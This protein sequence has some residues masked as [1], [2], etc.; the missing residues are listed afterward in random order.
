MVIQWLGIR[1]PIQGHRFDSPSRKIAHASE[2]LSFCTTTA[3][4]APTACAP[5]QE[6]PPQQEGCPPQLKSGPRPLL[7]LEKAHMSQG[8]CSTAKNK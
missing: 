1:L 7:H 8:R 3:E 4:P 6:K 5:Q 2:Q